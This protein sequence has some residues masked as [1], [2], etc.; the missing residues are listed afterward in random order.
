M[1]APARVLSRS[2]GLDPDGYPYETLKK[3]KAT[4]TRRPRGDSSMP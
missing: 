2:V 1:P 3:R 4:C